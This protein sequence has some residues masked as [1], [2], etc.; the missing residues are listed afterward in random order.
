[1]R[2]SLP[3]VA[4]VALVLMALAVAATAAT[5]ATDKSSPLTYDKALKAAKHEGKVLVIDF[6][7][8]W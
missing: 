8:D 6:Y 3:A 1:M 4:V 7:A 5:A 2:R